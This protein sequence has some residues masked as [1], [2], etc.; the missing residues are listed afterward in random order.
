[1]DNAERNG[2]PS[3]EEI[4]AS[5]R[6]IIAEDPLGASPI[7]DLKPKIVSAQSEASLEEHP[8]FDLP[9]IFRPTQPA[10]SDRPAPLFGRLTD[11]IR[12]AGPVADGKQSSSG[13]LSSQ[14]AGEPEGNGFRQQSLSSF[15][16]AR[17]ETSG[18]SDSHGDDL[19]RLES[20]SSSAAIPAGS[21]PLEPQ[22]GSLASSWRSSR[23]VIAQGAPKDNPPRVMT[24]FKDTRMVRMSAPLDETAQATHPEPLPAVTP[25]EIATGVDFTSIIPARLD[26]P[27]APVPAWPSPP[28]SEPAA[29]PP[30]P[31]P[32]IGL[33]DANVVGIA[34][35]GVF[36]EHHP[37]QHVADEHGYRTTPPADPYAAY[38]RQV[39]PPP[40]VD[41]AG[42]GTIEDTTAEL[43]RP[44]LRQWLAD[45][46]PRMVEKALHIEVAESVKTGKKF[47]GS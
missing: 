5:I 11:A 31:P 46:M 15:K 24:P 33:S 21:S 34:A 44:M 23:P 26:I 19:R 29:A 4:L 13:D 36:E 28:A 38:Q 47:N 40:H 32:P 25:T 17:S 10:A 3:M 6:R 7:I 27:G 1:M 42:S 20:S 43:L 12:N 45:N 16:A 37:T 22:S 18:A 9:A 2:Q 41:A 35:L 14:K 8:D 39:P 30:A